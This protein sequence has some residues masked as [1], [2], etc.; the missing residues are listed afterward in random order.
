MTHFRTLL[1]P[2]LAATLLTACGGGDKPAAADK[3]SAPQA[4]ASAPRAALTVTV[5]RPEPRVLAQ[6]VAANGNVAAWQEAIV[7]ANVQ[8]LRVADVKVNVGDVVR[9]GQVLA[10]FDAAPVRQ[11]EAQAQ[12]SL[13]EAEAALAEAA[14]NAARAA[15]VE[16]SGALS[17]QQI[18]QYRTA[19]KTARA[20]V[21][22][23]RAVVAAQRLRLDR[24]EVRAPDAGVISARSATVG[25]VADNGTELFR[26]VRRGRLEWR[27][28][29]M[30][31]DL[32]R[33]RPGQ[34]AELTLPG[35]PD[36]VP[37]VQG[38]VRQ[39]GPT[40]DPKT[41]YATVYVDLPAGSLARAGM[42]AS[43][44]IDVGESRALTV[45]QE[46]IVMRDGF[47]HVL[48]MQ[49]GDAVRLQRVRTGRLAGDRIELLD[50]LPEGATVV[51]RGAAFL[52]DG[53]HVRVV[54]DSEPNQAPAPASQA[55]AAIK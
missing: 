9:A 32:A 54:Q 3:A 23:A 47:A 28:D 10:T 21:Q 5:A 35:P 11:D 46:A 7:S 4:A 33:I 26:L 39:L 13:A 45:P 18:A 55:P 2:A 25:Q 52:N 1:I 50:A 40:V 37:R 38:T 42:F 6:Q 24:A 34:A 22:A 48:L 31:E 14:G 19:E 12:A 41:R 20:R 44:R 43:G 8:G 51:V 27:A 53:D 36:A 29:V 49:P 17:A 15:A 16:S 30:A